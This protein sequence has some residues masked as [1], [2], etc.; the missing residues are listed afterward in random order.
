MLKT[1]L[2]LE[3]QSCQQMITCESGA[4]CDGEISPIEFQDGCRRNGLE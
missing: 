3:N 1:A 2:I 4:S